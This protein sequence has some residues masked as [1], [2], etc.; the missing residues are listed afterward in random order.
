MFAIERRGIHNSNLDYFFIVLG[1]STKCEH[2]QVQCASSQTDDIYYS[3]K[4]SPSKGWRD[5]F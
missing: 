4:K 1:E 3:T 2:M 5:I